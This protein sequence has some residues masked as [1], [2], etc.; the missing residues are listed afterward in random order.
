MTK[1]PITLRQLRKLRADLNLLRD[2]RGITRRM[3]AKK[4][5]IHEAVFSRMMSGERP[6]SLARRF[7]HIRKIIEAYNDA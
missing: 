2:E 4:L 3:I 5:G 6:I 1:K 7:K